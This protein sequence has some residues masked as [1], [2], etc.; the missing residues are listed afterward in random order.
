MAANANCH[1]KGGGV[2]NCGCIPLWQGPGIDASGCSHWCYD[3]G[4]L[5]KK[6]WV[7]TQERLCTYTNSEQTEQGRMYISE[8]ILLTVNIWNYLSGV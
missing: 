7:R 1:Q 6:I 4:A 2:H 3:F 8:T 5:E